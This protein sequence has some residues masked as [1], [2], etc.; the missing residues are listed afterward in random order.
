LQAQ[1]V[2][3]PIA[4]KREIETKPWRKCDQKKKKQ[5][6]C[7]RGKYLLNEPQ[8]KTWSPP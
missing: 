5:R 2:S 1:N 4:A 3:K 8:R 7:E 6:I